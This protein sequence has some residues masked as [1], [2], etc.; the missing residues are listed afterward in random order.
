M[1]QVDPSQKQCGLVDEVFD[2]RSVEGEEAYL[3]GAS[4]SLLQ[5]FGVVLM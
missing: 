1:I 4:T 2:V 3:K 5:L